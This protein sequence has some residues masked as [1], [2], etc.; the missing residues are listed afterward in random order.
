SR[1]KSLGFL[2]PMN[3]GIAGEVPPRIDSVPSDRGGR[4]ALSRQCYGYATEIP[5]LYTLAIYNAI[6]NDGVFV[7]PRLVKE[8]RGTVDSILEP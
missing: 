5:P 6:A 1:I 2:E 8:L 3:T 4:I 7:R